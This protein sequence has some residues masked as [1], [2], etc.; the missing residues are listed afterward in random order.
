[1]HLQYLS[2]VFGVLLGNCVTCLTRIIRRKLLTLQ[3]FLFLKK[4][5]FLCENSFAS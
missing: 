5:C 1:M 4:Y 2:D 3:L